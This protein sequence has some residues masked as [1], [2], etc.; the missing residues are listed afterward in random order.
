MTFMSAILFAN[1]PQFNRQISVDREANRLALSLRKAQ[2]YALAVRE[3]NSTYSDDPFCTTPPVRFPPY[4]I[5]LS[6]TA[7][8]A[9]DPRNNTTYVIFGDA[10]CS[11]KYEYNDSVVGNEAVETVKVESG[12]APA[13]IYS[14]VGFSSAC[15]GS[16]CGLDKV[17]AT[18]QRPTPTINIRGSSG[19]SVYDNLDYVEV[20]IR[21]TGETT[22]RKVI[23]R[24]TGAVTVQ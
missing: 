16:G 15:P 24:N 20:A 1:Y 4:G 5:A 8:G 7:G 14:M 18:Y 2:A 13:I 19:V 11:K 23:I 10:T 6:T 22:E 3:F 17:H 9:G 21:I 12:R